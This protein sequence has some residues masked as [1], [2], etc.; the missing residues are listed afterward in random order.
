MFDKNEY[1]KDY[2]KNHPEYREKAITHAREH[3][4][5]PASKETTRNYIREHRIRTTMDG[6][7][8]TLFTQY[9]RPKTEKCELCSGTGFLS[10]HHWVNITMLNDGLLPGLWLCHKC[11]I[12]AELVDKGMIDIYVRKKKIAEYEVSKFRMVGIELDPVTKRFRNK[13]LVEVL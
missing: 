1:Q 3:H 8:I 2:Y 5:L 6:K 11:H 4:R 13:K 12:F 10:Y 7:S 9:K